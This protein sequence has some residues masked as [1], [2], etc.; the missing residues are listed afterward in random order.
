M[1]GVDLQQVAGLLGLNYDSNPDLS[2]AE[3]IVRQAA[4]L[5][6]LDSALDH[7]P[8]S[9]HEIKI[10]GR[11]RTVWNL[12]EHM[13]EIACVYQRVVEGTST[14]DAAAADAEV[15]DTSTG[16][17]LHSSISRLTAKLSV[18]TQDYERS[19]ETYFGPASLHYV[20]ERCTWHIAQHL[21]QL[22]SL[23][24]DI[25]TAIMP[26]V[27]AKLLDGLPIPIEVWD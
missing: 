4:L 14:F 12:V 8:K 15:T 19:V 1:H 16:E 10:P 6:I 25:D 20:L 13:C 24:R 26:E 9:A 22:A 2:P 23:M 5:S 11:D 17:Q 7:I 3:L 18:E 27:E 21:R